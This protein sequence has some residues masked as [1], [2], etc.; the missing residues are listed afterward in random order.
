MASTSKGTTT[1]GCDERPAS[2]TNMDRRV[3]LSMQGAAVSTMMRTVFAPPMLTR[4]QGLVVARARALPLAVTPLIQ[5]TATMRH[6]LRML[7]PIL[8]ASGRALHSR[9]AE[10]AGLATALLSTVTTRPVARRATS[11]TMLWSTV[12]GAARSSGAGG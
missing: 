11:S 7:V 2:C 3:G 9:G 5:S 6:K 4:I 12:A 1:R 10:G 8:R